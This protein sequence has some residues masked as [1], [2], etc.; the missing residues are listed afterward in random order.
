MPEG[1]QVQALLEKITALRTTGLR[2]EHV[3]FSFMKRRIQPLMGHNHLGSKYTGV[4]DSSRL[5]G[6]EIKKELIIERFGKSFKDMPLYTPCPVE[7][8][9]SRP[10]KKVNS[11]GLSPRTLVVEVVVLTLIVACCRRTSRSLYPCP[12]CPSQKNSPEQGQR[13]KARSNK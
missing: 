2:A 9:F 12:L 7:Y 3:A 6:E 1:L 11:R 13:G 10:P 8:S 5:H 4:D